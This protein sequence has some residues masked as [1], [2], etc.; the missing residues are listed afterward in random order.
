MRTFRVEV[1]AEHIAAC[2]LVPDVG[3]GFKSSHPEHKDPVELAMAQLLGKPVAC[4]QDEDTEMATIGDGA[5]VLVASLP[6]EQAAWIDRF[7]RGEPVEPFGFDVEIEDWLVD[8]VTKAA[9]A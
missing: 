9:P 1:T 5:N 2:A 4:D 6:R 7:Y 3:E 8:L